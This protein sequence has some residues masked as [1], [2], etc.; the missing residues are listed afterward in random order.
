MSGGKGN[1]GCLVIHKDLVLAVQ[2]KD[3]GKWCLPSGKPMG[4]ETADETAIRETFEESGLRVSI[5]K[6]LHI[7]PESGPFY[8][9]EGVLLEEPSCNLEIPLQSKN[10]IVKVAFID[11]KRIPFREFRFPEAMPIILKLIN[12]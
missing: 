11:F 7:F 6:L 9:F 1:A 10:E 5:K 12:P 8:L 3:T 4:D 2:M